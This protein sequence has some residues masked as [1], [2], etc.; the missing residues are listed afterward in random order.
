MIPPLGPD[1]HLPPGRY[2]CTLEEVERTFVRSPTI[3][4]PTRREDLFDG[5]VRYLTD[6]EDTQLATAATG[7]LLRSVWVGGSFVSDEPSPSDVDIS[8]I[9]DGLVA[10]S[11]AGKPG[12]KMIGKLTKHRDSIKARYGVEVFP[13]KWFPIERPFKA[14]LDLAGDELAYLSDRGKM[15]DWWQRCR[16]DGVDL[17]S[18][19][20]CETRRGY[21]EVMVDESS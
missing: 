19:E 1:G 11:V 12:S 4:D 13:V 17:P 8:P 7:Q 16:I 20:S 9:V 18:V 21:L 15:D 2:R 10:D 14:G 6:W 5:F 3:G